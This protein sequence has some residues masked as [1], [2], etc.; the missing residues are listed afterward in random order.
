[1]LNLGF[2]IGVKVELGIVLS[3]GLKVYL[4]YGF[5]FRISVSFRVRFMV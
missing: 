4:N 5:M 3:L 1:M 2:T